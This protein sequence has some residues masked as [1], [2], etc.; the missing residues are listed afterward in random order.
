MRRTDLT[1]EAGAIKLRGVQE[2]APGP[3]GRGTFVAQPPVHHDLLD[4][5]GIYDELV[6]R[7]GKLWEF[8]VLQTQAQVA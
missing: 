3:D 6:A 1:G 2:S 5:H 8:H 4:L 7:R